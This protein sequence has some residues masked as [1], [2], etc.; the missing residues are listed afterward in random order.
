MLWMTPSVWLPFSRSRGKTA[1]TAFEVWCRGWPV[2]GAI[3]YDVTITPC[4]C[5]NGLLKALLSCSRVHCLVRSHR[6]PSFTLL[7]LPVAAS[8]YFSDNDWSQYGGWR[9][10][11]SHIRRPSAATGPGLSYFLSAIFLSLKG[12]L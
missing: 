2:A 12:C 7:Q 11:I 8:V 4:V 10:W 5:D 1:V 9:H 6:W 3:F